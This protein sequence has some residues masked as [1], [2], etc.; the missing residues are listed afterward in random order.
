MPYK[1][2]AQAAWMHIHKPNIAKEFD[3]KTPEHAAGEL[4]EHVSSTKPRKP[5]VKRRLPK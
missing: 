4:P 5:R 3:R 1:S 2:L